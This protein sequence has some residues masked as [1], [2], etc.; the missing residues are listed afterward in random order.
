M[1]NS[2]GIVLMPIAPEPFVM[3]SS[4]NEQAWA[5]EHKANREWVAQEGT[6][7]V[8]H[9]T[10]PYYIGQ[11]EITVGQYRPFVKATRYSTEGERGRWPAIWDNKRKTWPR[12][13]GYSWKRPGYPQ[14]DSYPA[15]CLAWTDADAYCRWLTEKE[16]AQGLI[17]TSVVYRLPT[18]AEW[19]FANRGTNTTLFAWGNDPLLAERH[20]N[21]LDATLLPDGNH[22]HIEYFPWEDGYAFSAP[23]ASYQ[24]T[25]HGLYD[26]HGNAW[27]WCQNSFYMYPGGIET[28]PFGPTGIWHHVLRGGSWDN[29]EGSFRSAARRVKIPIFASDATGFRIVLAPPTT[30]TFTP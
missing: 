26:M 30:N 10:Y 11:T 16:Q 13:K 15:V 22:W 2:L 5:V 6:A 25:L 8:V 20:A 23:V 28:N 14:D 17:P 21:V 3:G 18:E 7:T 29:R 1:T 19:E 27:E 4:S 12:T 24:P 9:I